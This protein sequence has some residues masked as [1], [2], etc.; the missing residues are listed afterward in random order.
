MKTMNDKIDRKEYEE[1]KLRIAKLE[2][3]IDKINDNIRI[4]V[5]HQVSNQFLIEKNE[6]KIKSLEE[7]IIRKDNE[8]AALSDQAESD[9][10]LDRATLSSGMPLFT[11]WDWLAI[12]MIE[13]AP[14]KTFPLRHTSV[15]GW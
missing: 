14:Y 13:K 1:L 7:L 5:E 11:L 10:Q 9:D 2:N 8:I 3:K 15:K 12:P 6:E 4:G